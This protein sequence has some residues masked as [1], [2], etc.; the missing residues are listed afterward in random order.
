VADGILVVQDDDGRVS[1]FRP[2][3]PKAAKTAPAPAPA[4][5]E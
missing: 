1:A 4:K 2:R 3:E 5:T